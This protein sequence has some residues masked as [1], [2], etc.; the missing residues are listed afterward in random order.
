MK[1]E[2]LSDINN[3]IARKFGIVFSLNDNL[4]SIYRNFGIN[5]PKTQGNNKH[6]LPVPATYVINSDGTIVLFHVDIDY[7][8]R[9]EP[10]EVL[11]VLKNIK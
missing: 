5:L 11:E 8:K 1:F 9:L 2:I 3:D 6:E 10:E 4:K 7:T